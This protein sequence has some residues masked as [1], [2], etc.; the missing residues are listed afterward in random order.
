MN[1]PPAPRVVFLGGPGLHY[2]ERRPPADLAPW[3]AT[4]W[5]VRCLHRSELRILPDGCVDLIGS[6]VIGPSTSAGLVALEPG[7]EATGVR[8]RP[9]AFPALFGVPANELRDLRVALSRS[10][11]RGRCTRSR[12][13]HRRPTRSPR[14]R[15]SPGMSARSRARRATASAICAGGWTPPRVTVP[16]A[17]LASVGCRRC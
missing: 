15:S 11:D 4:L 6:D 10:R 9:G 1:P 13:M 12:E 17:W 5:H 8:L 16:S 3:V 7:E 2:T 14:R